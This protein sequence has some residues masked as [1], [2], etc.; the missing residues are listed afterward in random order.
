MTVEFDIHV[1]SERGEGRGERAPP[2][3]PGVDGKG[4]LPSPLSL[5]YKPTT[6]NE[7]FVHHHVPTT[8]QHQLHVSPGDLISP[9]FVVDAPDFPNLF[10]LPALAGKCDCDRQIVFVQLDTDGSREI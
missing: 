4:P 9:P 5:L 3:S 10:D 6:T 2:N 7:V 1:G 8:Y